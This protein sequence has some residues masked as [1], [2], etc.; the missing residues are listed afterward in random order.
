MNKFT[1]CDNQTVTFIRTQ[2]KKWCSAQLPCRRCVLPRSKTC[3]ED[4]ILA[5]F[6][7]EN[8]KWR[9]LCLTE[10]FD[11]GNDLNLN[12]KFRQFCGSDI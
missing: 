4:T 5:S 12:V 7:C 11:N 9:F 10:R 1:K 3:L 6:D 8:C 2:G